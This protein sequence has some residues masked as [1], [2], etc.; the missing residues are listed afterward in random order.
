MRSCR[1]EFKEEKDEILVY[2]QRIVV[3]NYSI[4]IDKSFT[5]ILFEDAKQINARIKV[6]EIL[7]EKIDPKDFGHFAV[8]D[9]KNRLTEELTKYQKEK[10]YSYF[11]NLEFQV[12]QTRV[13]DV[14][15]DFYRLDIGKDITTLL[16]KKE[17]LPKDDFHIGDFV[18]V[19][20]STVEMKTKGPKIYVTR[21]HPNLIVKLLES[22]I[23]EIKDKTIEIMGVSRDAGDRSK[24]GVFSNDP[25][26]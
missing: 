15:D 2:K 13:L 11:K 18:K 5:Q 8:R 23:P 12:V 9:F 19:Y 17:S 1:V 16:P 22:L 21:T 6:G 20:V 25:K 4:D 14:K 3:E 24:I 10:L 26:S 7:E